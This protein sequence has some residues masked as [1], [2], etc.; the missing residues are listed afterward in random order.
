MERR[1]RLHGSSGRPPGSSAPVVDIDADIEQGSVERL[2]DM[3]LE[4]LIDALTHAI[5][6]RVDTMEVPEELKERLAPGMA[7]T[8]EGWIFS[9]PELARAEG[10]DWP[11]YAQT[12]IG[13]ERMRSVRRCVETALTENV[14]GDL[15]EAGPWRGGWAS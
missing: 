1:S 6:P 5:Y 15:I 14:S 9:Y 7:E 3:Y 8:G 4:L 12:M 2:R 13:L 10:R 11:L